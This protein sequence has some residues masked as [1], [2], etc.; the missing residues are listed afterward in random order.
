MPSAWTEADIPDLSGKTAVVTGAN[1]G[2]GKATAEALAAKGATVVMACRSR[3]RADD[4][5]ADILSRHADA[6][7]T[8]EMLDLSRLTSAEGFAERFREKHE[9]LDLLYLNAGIMAVPRR[10]TADGFEQQF[11][12]NVL[13]HF[14]LA[15]RL[16][17]MLLETEGSRT[18]W[19]SSMAAWFGTIRFHDLQGE[20]SYGR[21]AAYNQS[22]LADLMLGLEMNARLQAAGEASMALVAHPGLTNTDLQTT[23]VEESSG[24]L[25]A[26]VEGFFYGLTMD[27]LAMTPEAG[28]LPQLRA[29]TDP[30]ARGGAFYGPRH[31]MRGRPVEVNPPKQALSAGKRARLWRACE[32]LTGVSFLSA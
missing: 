5:R 24:K 9:R 29:G 26:K 12:V 18:V 7:L 17:P 13:G 20:T 2:L 30:Q 28:A 1:S 15:G 11:G 14:A 27:R 25:E 6:D 10:E 21:W 3:Q 8:V 19:L 22:K 31:Q 4:A 16:L 23:S 32:E